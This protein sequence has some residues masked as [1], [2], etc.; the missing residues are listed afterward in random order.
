MSEGASFRTYFEVEGEDRSRLGAQVGEQR[1]RVA[2]RLAEIRNVVA[3]MSGKG[4]VG[5]SYLTAALAL[6]LAR[7]LTRG[8]GVVDADLKSPTVARL[9]GAAGPLALS[10]EGVRPALGNEN[11][12]VIST[13]FLLADGRPLRW[14]EP[15]H[16]RFVWRGALEAGVLREFLA[17][18]AWGPL[19]LL[20]IDLPPGADGVA[21]VAELAPSLKG[22]VSVTL[23]TDES[24]QSVR[25]AMAS[26]QDA[27]IRLLGV[28]ENMSGYRCPSCGSTEP[29]FPGSAGSRLAEDFGVPLLAQVPFSAGAVEVPSGLLDR[30]LETLA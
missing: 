9:L 18:V 11:I 7:R 23:P 16:E 19:E 27:G 29:L 5:K 1:R 10:P 21:D 13:D 4:G 15:E 6:G 8:V 20:V 17:D 14:R 25:R 2:A 12:R 26:A 30:F 3:V 28:I 22:A 24:Y